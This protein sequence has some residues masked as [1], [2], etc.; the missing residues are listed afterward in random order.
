M[1]AVGKRLPVDERKAAVVVVATKKGQPVDWETRLT[2][3]SKGKTVLDYGEN[4]T[5]FMQGECADSVYFLLR[6]KV[7][8]AV[9]TPEGKEAIVAT[10]GVGEF[11]GE[12]CLA[13]QP[14]RMVT[15]TSVGA[16]ML[17]KVDKPSMARALHDEQGLAELFTAHLLTRIIRY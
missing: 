11:F 15:A 10:L 3:I 13:G 8:L 4:H 12:G 9:T 7:K 1:I 16:C 17:A 5:V 6:G 2:G 14:L